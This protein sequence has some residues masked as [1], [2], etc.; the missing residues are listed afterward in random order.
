[1]K[2]ARSAGKG[3]VMFCY[4]CEHGIEDNETFFQITTGRSENV[5]E[6]DY[7]V[8]VD[9]TLNICRSCADR[10]ITLSGLDF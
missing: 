8:S 3:E 7:P 4:L 10:Q 2:K 1:M 6:D 9:G 5:A